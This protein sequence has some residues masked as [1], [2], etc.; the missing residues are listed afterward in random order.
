MTG[1]KHTKSTTPKPETRGN[2]IATHILSQKDNIAI[3]TGGNSGIGFIT[4]MDLVRKGAHVVLACRNR[5]RGLKAEAEIQE[6]I[7]SAPDPGT[8]KFML[9]DISD[10][11]C[12]H[13][14]CKTFKKM[15]LD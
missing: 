2:W 11:S 3:V 6:L 13:N 7:I 12:V 9:V 14:F 8:L 5:E 15:H 10:L 4:A 1:G